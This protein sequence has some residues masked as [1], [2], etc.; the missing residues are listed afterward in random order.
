M[1]NNI[2]VRFARKPASIKEV[3]E[4][5]VNYEIEFHPVNVIETR[6]MS[7]REYDQ[8]TRRFLDD[9]DWLEGKGDWNGEICQAVAVIAPERYT[10]YIYPSGYSYARYVGLNINHNAQW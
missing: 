7:A 10:L 9:H 4:V 1:D 6:A 3:M 8:F 2:L 5:A